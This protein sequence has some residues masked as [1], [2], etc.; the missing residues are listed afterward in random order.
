MAVSRKQHGGHFDVPA[1]I[2]FLAVFMF[3]KPS[4]VYVMYT[5]INSCLF[6]EH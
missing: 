2:S 5:T 3:E 1:D 4:F 6:L